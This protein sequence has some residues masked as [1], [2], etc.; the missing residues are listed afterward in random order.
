[1]CPSCPSEPLLDLTD[2]QTW[3]YF[4]EESARERARRFKRVVALCL[5]FA[6]VIVALGFMVGVGL[7]VSI[8]V[9]SAAIFG[10]ATAITKARPLPPLYPDMTEAEYLALRSS[11]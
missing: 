6:V 8:P 4:E 9:V 11:S 10:A 7:I 2:E 5:P 3:L 1:M